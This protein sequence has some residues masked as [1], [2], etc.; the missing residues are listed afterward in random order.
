MGSKVG[1]AAAEYI[2]ATVSSW[3]NVVAEPHRFGGV[4]FKVGRRELRG[5][6]TVAIWSISPSR[7]GSTTS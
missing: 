4:E 1:N 2:R 7:S 3:P 6:C 5:T